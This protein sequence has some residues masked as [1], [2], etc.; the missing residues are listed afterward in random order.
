MS[1]SV[2][3]KV[4]SYA[5]VCCSTPLVLLPYGTQGE[6]AEAGLPFLSM[7]LQVVLILP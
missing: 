4:F 2:K 6:M 5:P 3:V 7:G 1:K